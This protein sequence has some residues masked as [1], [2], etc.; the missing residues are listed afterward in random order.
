MIIP[1]DT[2]GPTPITVPLVLNP[3]VP[4]ARASEQAASRA[5]AVAATL[6]PKVA[7]TI[8]KVVV[9]MLRFM[10]V[11]LYCDFV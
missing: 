1:A 7:K 3:Y 11:L 5:C 4:A 2:L 8:S 10:R 6:S 9:A